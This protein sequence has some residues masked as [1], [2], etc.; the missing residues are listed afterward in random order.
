MKSAFY[1]NEDGI[2]EPTVVLNNHEE[3]YNLSSAL[4]K[5][6]RKPDW[7]SS[8]FDMLTSGKVHSVTITRAHAYNLYHII[9]SMARVEAYKLPGSLKGNVA[10][11]IGH[12]SI[13]TLYNL[14]S[15]SVDLTESFGHWRK[16]PARVPA[17]FYDGSKDA[18]EKAV[19]FTDLSPMFGAYGYDG[20]SFIVP[21]MEGTQTVS[22]GSYLVRGPEGEFYPVTESSMKKLRTEV[23]GSIPFESM[24]YVK[25][26]E[27][28]QFDV[29][30]IAFT[31]EN[32]DA[33]IYAI[34]ESLPTW[35]ETTFPR[36]GVIV[37]RTETRKYVGHSGDIVVIQKSGGP[38]VR[39]V[40]DDVFRNTYQ[41][42]P[43]LI[44]D[45]VQ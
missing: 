18:F 42:T 15:H 2:T 32:K 44:G 43:D 34:D 24:P 23:Q 41:T 35:H 27:N 9:S 36:P 13:E 22:P 28:I 31:E 21:T 45:D 1:I 4:D 12:S 10:Y 17:M 40:R 14:Y 39:F 37:L 38:S 5:L 30:A 11:A 16:R 33:I 25:S 29:M 3:N 6:G 8:A 20:S 7:Y 26:W 19:S